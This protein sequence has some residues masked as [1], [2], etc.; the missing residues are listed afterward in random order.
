MI[1][2]VK[3]QNEIYLASETGR[4]TVVNAMVRV[5]GLDK[6]KSIKSCKDLYFHFSQKVLLIFLDKWLAK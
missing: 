1:F 2:I 3:G 6:P 4:I 5:Q